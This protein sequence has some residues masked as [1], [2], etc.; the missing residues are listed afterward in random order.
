MYDDLQYIDAAILTDPHLVVNQVQ[1]EAMRIVFITPSDIQ[2]DLKSHLAYFQDFS[3]R[4]E[5]AQPAGRHFHEFPFHSRTS[6]SMLP[7]PSRFS[8]KSC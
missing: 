5:N 1:I 7:V 3:S 6:L 8:L 2:F 4:E